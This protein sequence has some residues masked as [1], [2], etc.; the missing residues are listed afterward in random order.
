VT[1]YDFVDA[2]ATIVVGGNP[3]TLNLTTP[4]QNGSL[5][6][7]GTAGHRVSLTMSSSIGG[8][9][10]CTV[11]TIKKAD[12]N[13]IVTNNC[14]TVQ[15]GFIEP[16]AIATTDTYTITVDPPS[17]A[18]GAMTLT[19]YD[20]PADVTG[21]ITAGGSSPT[22]TLGTPGQNGSLTFTGANQERISLNLPNVTIGGFGTCTTVTIN[23]PDGSPLVSNGCVTIQ[24]G[25]IDVQTL[26]TAGTYTIVVDPPGGA[27]GDMTLSLYDVTDA[28]G[29]V[30]IN[31]AALPLTLSVPGQ[32]ANITVAGTSGQSISVPVTTPGYWVCGSVTLL[33]ADNVTTVASTFNCGPTIT[34]PSTTLPATETYHI[35]LDP[36]GG[37]TGNYSV[38][39]TSP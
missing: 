1:L 39:V 25:F 28:T 30:T 8:F 12:G 27:T 11:V 29:S 14:V 21:T 4:G 13:P 32:N 22:I 34:L 35:L 6:F 18:T 37:I 16:Q 5:T 26:P 31:G 33:R 9:G 10:T 38:S 17:S 15:G 7:T 23:K 36:S 20:V 19:L 2:T 24:G 3:Q